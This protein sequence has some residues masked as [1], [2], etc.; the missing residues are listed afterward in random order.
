MEPGFF[1]GKTPTIMTT[2]PNGHDSR[3]IDASCGSAEPTGRRSVR[4]SGASRVNIPM[5]DGRVRAAEFFSDRVPQRR[6]AHSQVRTNV[7]RRLRVMKFGGTSVG[8]ASCI[9]RVVEIIRAAARESNVA[10]V[11]SA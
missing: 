5:P 6:A 9:A 11:V 2:L 8:D 7:D 3:V 1:G 10:V 4:L